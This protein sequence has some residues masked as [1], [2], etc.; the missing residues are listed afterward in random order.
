M[1][2][3]E[4]AFIFPCVGDELLGIVAVP[5]RPAA[6][7]VL[8]IVG[9]PQYRVGSHRQF[10][11]LAHALAAAG[12][13][14]M[15]FDYRGMGDSGGAL[16]DF[17]SV[18]EDIA[19][20]IDAFYRQCPQLDRVVLWG[21]CDAAS[22]S[23]LYCD[24][25]DDPRVQGLVLLNPWVRSA[26]TLAR[27]Q[28]KHYYRQRLL[29]GEFWRKLLSGKVGI[30][31]SSSGLATS[32]LALFG[33]GGS[34]LRDGELSFQQ[35]MA[36]GLA[37]RRRPVLLLLSGADYTAREFVECVRTE[38]DWQAALSAARL[39]RRE[40][41][42]ADHTFSSALWRLAVAQELIA[43]LRDSAGFE[44]ES[45]ATVAEVSRR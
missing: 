2:F 41:S 20:A 27:T 7:G 23:L 31:R 10:L 45:L 25:M 21:L 40:L 11:L 8:V 43:W 3:S 18:D 16:R 44:T 12:Y 32:L 33:K 15:R 42:E 38:S 17:E 28:A 5:E 39:T 29:Q 37:A 19:A 14:V 4:E 35:K 36:R 9:G 22:A 34:A 6:T 24:A 13:P 30:G 26:T 1:N